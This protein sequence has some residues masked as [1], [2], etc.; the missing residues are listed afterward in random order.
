MLTLSINSF[1]EPDKN[2]SGK[3]KKGVNS[4]S[5]DIDL[6]LLQMLT[7]WI[8]LFIMKSGFLVLVWVS[9]EK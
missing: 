3:F 1:V 9:Q 2:F 7:N 5:S 8:L 6:I 4:Y